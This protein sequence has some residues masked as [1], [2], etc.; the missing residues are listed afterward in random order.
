[1]SQFDSLREEMVAQ[2]VLYTSFIATETG[3][4]EFSER[5]LEVMRDVPRHEFVPA[6]I[7]AMAYVDS[8]LPIGFGKTISQPF[9]VAL[10]TDLLDVHSEDRVLEVGTGLGYQAAVLARLAKTV[11][12]VEII[13]DL[14][15]QAEKNLSALGYDN[16]QIGIGDGSAG[17]PEH[18]PFDKILVA[19]APELIPTALLNQLKPGGR[20][21]VPAGIEDAQQLI[22]VEKDEQSRHSTH[23][24]LRVRFSP[25][26][27]AH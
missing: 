8:P 17:W 27:T 15:R 16:I 12:T 2:I 4:E 7:Q 10:M 21:V 22:L 19:A 1:M 25:L 13:E 18:A 5:V 11:Y 9:I 24:I 26:V 6:N 3:I 14:A 23:E 20:M